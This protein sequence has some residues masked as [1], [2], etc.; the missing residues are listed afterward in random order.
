M[1]EKEYNWGSGPWG[2]GPHH[3]HDGMHGAPCCGPESFHMP[4]SIGP[5]MSFPFGGQRWMHFLR[6]VN[7]ETFM[8]YE[9]AETDDTY[10]VNNA[11]TRI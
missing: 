8:P 6:N 10:I 9:L 5:W 11:V 2:H 3:Q 1:D 7:W 4:P